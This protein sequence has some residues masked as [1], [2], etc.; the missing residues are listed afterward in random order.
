MKHKKMEETSHRFL[1]H[2]KKNSEKIGLSY[3][4]QNISS[5]LR[6]VVRSAV[7][8]EFNTVHNTALH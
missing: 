7:T 3:V 8:N 4:T 2:K 5:N 1:T 6:C